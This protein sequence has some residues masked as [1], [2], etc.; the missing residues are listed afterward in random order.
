MQIYSFLL[1]IQT[2]FCIFFDKTCLKM[3]EQVAHKKF[4]IDKK[5]R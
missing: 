2:F 5:M 3:R 1:N 4:G